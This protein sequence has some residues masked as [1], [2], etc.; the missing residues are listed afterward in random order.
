MANAYVVTAHKATAVTSCVTG[1]MCLCLFS[2]TFKR[3]IFLVQLFRLVFF[4]KFH[5]WE[6][7][8]FDIGKKQPAGSSSCDTGGFTTDERNWYKWQNFS[9]EIVPPT[10]KQASY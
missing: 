3:F 10:G 5:F 7:F 6:G 9:Y 8:E 1:K 4:R 2:L